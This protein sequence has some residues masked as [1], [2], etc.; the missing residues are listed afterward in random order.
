[1]YSNELLKK[2]ESGNTE[3]MLELAKTYLTGDG[4][5]PNPSEAMN[6]I[7][8][9]A[10][11]G[12]AEAQAGMADILKG[13]GDFK[14]AFEWEEKAANQGRL[15]S[16][17]NLAIYYGEGK[18]TVKNLEKEFYWLQ[19]AAQGGHTNAKHNLALCYAEG[20]GTTKDYTQAVNWWEQ[21][22]KEGNAE[23]KASLGSCYYFGLGVT[24]DKENGRR[25]WKEA[26]AQGSVTAKNLLRSNPNNAGTKNDQEMKNRIIMSV[27]AAIGLIV[28]LVI[29]GNAPV[30]ICV[31]LGIG[32]GGNIF[33]LFSTLGVRMLGMFKVSRSMGD[34]VQNS[35][36]HT[37]IEAVLVCL[38]YVI[39][40]PIL[41]I[42]QMIM[43]RPI[44]LWKK[45]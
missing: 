16:Q 2:A 44:K 1:M 41:F 37:L 45:G 9:A 38:F 5:S 27:G 17:Y 4:V 19:K 11:L 12:D 30:F 25:L 43:G 26:E 15:V 14:S 13:N 33:Y 32:I 24:E 18:G 23:G 42:I 28:G 3:A 39:G 34:S 22:S 31:W 7:E 6:W 10:T 29:Q 21:A 36:I 20:K 8:K 40:G 35:I